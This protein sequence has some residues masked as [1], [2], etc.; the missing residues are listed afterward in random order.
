MIVAA[1]SN[2]VVN[3]PPFT[4]GTFAPVV[5]TFTTPDPAQPTD[6]VL[7]AASTFHAAF[8][9]VRCGG[10]TPTPVTSTVEASA[11]LESIGTEN[12]VWNPVV[13]SWFTD[14]A[15]Q[16]NVLKNFVSKKTG[17]GAIN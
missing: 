14:A 4:P 11:S 3:I 9:R 5:V 12:S 1:P 13:S 16:V 2:A 15:T 10:V 8:I 7:R 6:F 17:N